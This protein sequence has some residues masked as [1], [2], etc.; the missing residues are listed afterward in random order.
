MRTTVIHNISAAPNATSDGE[1][2]LLA[3]SP[4]I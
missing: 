1:T 2:K 3:N 4:A